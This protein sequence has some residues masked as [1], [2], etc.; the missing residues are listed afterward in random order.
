MPT[1]AEVFLT[2]GRQYFKRF[3][4][5]MLPGHIKALWDIATCRTGVKGGRLVQ[6]DKCGHTYYVYHSCCNRSCPQCH[7]AKSQLWLEK[8]KRELLD[9][10]YF[11]LVF[12]LP[13]EIRRTARSN[14]RVMYGIL[15][16]A[17]V[18]ALKKLGAD[19]KYLGGQMGIL[20][21]LH[22]WSRTLGCH[23]HLHCLV[24]GIGIS[25]DKQEI[26]TAKYNY[27]VPAKALSKIFRARFLL[28]AKKELPQKVFQQMCLTKITKKWVVYSKPT[29][30]YAEKS[31]GISG[32]ISLSYCNYK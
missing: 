5:A 3:A 7:G 26:Y 14:Q 11:H 17:A 20:A 1:L 19:T 29:F 8:R 31:A 15:F 27:L 9:V 18:Y 24:P 10:P 21:V 13:Q 22:T 2:F 12:T 23:P 25:K 4:S 16:K 6:C 30:N 32:A 28:L